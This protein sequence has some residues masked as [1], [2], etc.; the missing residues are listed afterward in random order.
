MNDYLEEKAQTIVTKLFTA[1][2]KRNLKSIMQKKKMLMSFSKG[3]GKKKAGV[4]PNA[5]ETVLQNIMFSINIMKL[6]FL[7]TNIKTYDF[8]DMPHFT[9]KEVR[10]DKKRFLCDKKK[11][12]F[13]ED[14]RGMVVDTETKQPSM[15]AVIKTIH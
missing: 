9:L 3:F 15:F 10:R 13:F 5:Q 12:Q 6:E 11:F 14:M 8:A 2:K 7:K 4:G 1:N